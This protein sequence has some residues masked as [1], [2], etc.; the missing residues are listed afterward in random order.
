MGIAAELLSLV[1]NSSPRRN[2]IKS[3]HHHVARAPVSTVHIELPSDMA[4]YRLFECQKCGTRS[5]I[6][7]ERVKE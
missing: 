5:Y 3:T 4:G 2:R 6:P 1:T 7:K